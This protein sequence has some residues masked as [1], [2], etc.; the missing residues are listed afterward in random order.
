MLHPNPFD[1][2]IEQ[3][4]HHHEALVKLIER[5]S[6]VDGF[7]QRQHLLPTSVNPLQAVHRNIMNKYKTQLTV[8]KIAVVLDHAGFV[9][10]PLQGPLFH[11]DQRSNASID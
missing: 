2:L 10:V 7:L 8:E 5:T 6:S 1:G 4:A 3:T 11:F 9:L